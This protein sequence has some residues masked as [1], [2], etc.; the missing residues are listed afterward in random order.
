[1]TGLSGVDAGRSM[2]AADATVV[3]NPSMADAGSD[4]ARARVRPTA[5]GNR[6]AVSSCR[7]ASWSRASRKRSNRLRT[8]TGGA[9]GSGDG[10]PGGVRSRSKRTIPIFT[11]P[12]PSVMAWWIFM[13]TAARSSVRPSTTVISHRGRSWSK[14]CMAMG[15][16]MRRT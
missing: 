10:G 15:S 5:A 4:A 12:T 16:A 14:P 9:A 7:R 3:P 2:R 8:W 13:M 1:M 6:R 11:A